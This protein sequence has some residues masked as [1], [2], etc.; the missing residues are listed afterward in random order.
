MIA[1]ESRS[2]ASGAGSRMPIDGEPARPPSQHPDAGV[3]VG[4][5]EPLGGGGAEHDGRQALAGVVEEASVGELAAHRRQHLLV[6]G[7]ARGCRP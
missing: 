4:H 1:A 6:G 7:D 3:G 5:A 2:G